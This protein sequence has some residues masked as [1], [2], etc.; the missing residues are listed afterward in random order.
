MFAEYSNQDLNLIPEDIER[1]VKRVFF[2]NSHFLESKA[3][4]GDADAFVQLRDWCLICDTIHRG[5]L[6][7]GVA[8]INQACL[9]PVLICETPYLTS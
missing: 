4:E 6:A 3:A 2:L 5:A 8:P 1:F 9:S 7:E